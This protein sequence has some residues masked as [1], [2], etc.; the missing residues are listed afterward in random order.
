MKFRL[1]Y[2]LLAFILIIACNQDK[3]YLDTPLDQLLDAALTRAAKSGDKNDFILPDETDF[4]SIPQ[5][6]HNP[7][8]K[9]KV[10]LGK[11]LF[12]ETGLGV[13]PN[14]EAGKQTYSC[15]SC[16]IPSAGYRPGGVQGI[17]DGGIG[18]G[19]NGEG[20]TKLSAYRDYE[21]DVQGLRPLSVLN[22]AFV[23]NS[24]WNGR[25]GSEH[26]NQ[27][28]E[29]RWLIEEGTDR[30]EEGLA[31]LETQNIE[32][33]DLHRMEITEEVLDDY[34]Y[35]PY[36]DAAFGDLPE[37][38]RYTKRTASF[39]IS[40]Y[41]RALISNRAPFQAYLKGKKDALSEQEKRGA[42]LFFSKARCY[43]CHKE[44]N[45]GSNEFYALGVKDLY[46]TG[47]A[48][49]TSEAD[50]G[51]FGRG[52]FTGNA[53]DMF[54]FRVPQLYNLGDD[55]FYFHG[56]SKQTLREVVEYFNAG[57]PE[58]DKV[59]TSQ[60]ARQIRPLNLTEEEMDNLTAFLD[61]GLKDPDLQ[62]YVPENVLSGK[63]FPNNDLFSQIELGCGE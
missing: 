37:E 63:C 53:E 27:G 19:Q 43:Q 31:A 51:N 40:A 22:V 57:I 15:A 7:L 14:K 25:F 26:A 5:D 55:D 20:R 9:E 39:A 17:A 30:N 59:P 33:M 8:T 54:K 21:M 28:T 49:N 12:F 4:A 42:L 13:V 32:G 41:L 45:L 29:D 10:H 44:A 62:R 11:W 47:L 1:L 23:E 61:N 3:I 48:F 34:G 2:L 52:A 38:E 18:F 24:T 50:T 36:F 56:S 6:P 58:N 35:R 60:I 46:Q 16:H